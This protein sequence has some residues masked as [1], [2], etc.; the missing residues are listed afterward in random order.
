[1]DTR[2]TTET[3]A[4][5]PETTARGA[6]GRQR[7]GDLLALAA[8]RAVPVVR[9][10]GDERLAAP[11][12]CAEYDVRDL[13]NHLFQVVEQFRSLAAKGDADFSSTP[14][15]VAEDPGWR[16]R[17]AKE[18]DA[19]VAAWSAPGADEGTAGAMGL[20]AATVGGMALL[21]LTVHAWD[22]ARATGQEYPVDAG[23]LPV[24]EALRATV[25]ELA[26]MARSRGVFGAPVP[27]AADAPVLDRLLAETG[28]D[29]LWEG[30]GLGRAG[31]G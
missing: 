3:E 24:V 30:A 13:L 7:I 26:P 9:G 27:V 29:P 25:A 23:L 18:T 28:R 11:T 8:A 14:D 17:F 19:L 10:I 2:D 6:G 5:A 1:M 15:R 12:P 31:R 16:E 4:A 20:P 21:D 22:L